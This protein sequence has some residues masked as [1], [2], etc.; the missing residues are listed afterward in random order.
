[1]TAPTRSELIEQ[2]AWERLRAA[3]FLHDHEHSPTSW[4]DGRRAHREWS[5]AY[6]NLDRELP[7]NDGVV[8]P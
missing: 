8:R 7:A 4:F 2:A 3:L 1:M 5:A 6:L